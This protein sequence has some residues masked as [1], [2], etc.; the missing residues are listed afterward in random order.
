MKKPG[1]KPQRGKKLA[2]RILLYAVVI[3]ICLVILYPYFI[4][5]TSALKSRAE[6]YSMKGTLFPVRWRWSNL[7]DIWKKAPMANY[8]VNS[9]II[10]FGSTAI[11]MLCGI[12]AAYALTRMRW[13]GQTVFLGVII[14]S[15]MFAP[16][17]LVIGIYKIM[18]TFNLV[19]SLMGLILV[20][21]A[22]NQAF[23]VWLL[24]GTFD[25]ISPEMEKAAEIDGCSRI[26]SMFRVLLPIAAPG[27][28]TTLIF[29]F[30]NAWNEYTIALTLI[31]DD[32]VKPLTVGINI[33][34]GYN[35]VEWQYL[36][37][38]SLFSIVPVIILFVAIEKNLVGGL[39]S[40]GVK[41]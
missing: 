29:V 17:V 6:I 12:P 19:N 25:S 9:L 28:V 10:S 33:F 13:K 1:K 27:I 21:A 4:M 39:A 14:V 37:A 22:F 11:A 32:V 31:S 35:M 5:F 30:I 7:L 34:N 41:G 2:L 40:G 23:T 8:F 15:Q 36:F 24:R 3:L 38:A 26:Q 16:V 18:M 20:N